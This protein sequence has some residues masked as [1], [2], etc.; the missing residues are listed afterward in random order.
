MVFGAGLAVPHG[1]VWVLL[2]PNVVT[3][4]VPYIIAILAGT[5]V[6]AGILSF[7]KKNVSETSGSKVQYENVQGE[8]KL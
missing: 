2:I 6:T 7:V 4:L 8:L 3:Q 1:G 5:V